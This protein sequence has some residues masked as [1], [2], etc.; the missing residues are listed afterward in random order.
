MHRRF[1]RNI[2]KYRSINSAGMAARLQR[3]F[4]I[5]YVYTSLHVIDMFTRA[6][7]GNLVR[8]ISASVMI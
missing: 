2:L 1:M 4:R 5:Y 7:T 8:N 6:N 3:C